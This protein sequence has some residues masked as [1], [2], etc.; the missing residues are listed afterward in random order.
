MEP[1]KRPVAPVEK[2]STGDE[3]Q[4]QVKLLGRFVDFFQFHLKK[5]RITINNNSFYASLRYEDGRRWPGY[6]LPC[7]ESSEA[8]V[9]TGDE[10]KTKRE[11]TSGNTLVASFRMLFKA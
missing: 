5:L 2:L 7:L 10:E 1:K 4:D 8:T 3:L 11:P 6:S 9:E